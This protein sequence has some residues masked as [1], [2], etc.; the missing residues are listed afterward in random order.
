MMDW[1]IQPLVSMVQ[2]SL[3]FIYVY[4]RVVM[5]AFTSSCLVY[6]SC[7]CLRIGMSNSYCVVFLLCLSSSYEHYVTSFSGLSILIAPLVFFNIYSMIMQ[8]YHHAL[9]SSGIFKECF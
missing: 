8:A 5:S 6:V 3:S 2:Y 9:T 4:I 7:A 1:D